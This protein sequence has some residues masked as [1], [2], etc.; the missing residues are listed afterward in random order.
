MKTNNS[1]FYDFF[2]GNNSWLSKGTTFILIAAPFV[3]TRRMNY[4]VTLKSHV[5]NLTKV[6]VKIKVITWSKKV[7]LHISWSVLSSWTHLRCFYRSSLF[8]SNYYCRKTVRM[9]FH[10]LKWSLGHKERSLVSIFRFRVSI[11]PVTW[12]WRV[13]RVVF[14]QKRRLSIFSH[15][16]TYNGD[17]TKLMWP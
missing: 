6:K 5:E 8:L 3:K 2:F 7:M 9:T 10:D 14:V 4:D 15:W 11:L 17:V 13:F 16:L 12:C 1:R